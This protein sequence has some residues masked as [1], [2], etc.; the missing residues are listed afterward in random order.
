M[1]AD[2]DEH[3]LAVAK[4]D[5][6][7]KKFLKSIEPQ[8]LHGISL[9]IWA[10]AMVAPVN[11]LEQLTNSVGGPLS[12]LVEHLDADIQSALDVWKQ[13]GTREA[14]LD[15]ENNQPPTKKRKTASGATSMQASSAAS[16][17]ASDAASKAASDATSKEASVATEQ[18]SD[19]RVQ[20][21]ATQVRHN[22]TD[23]CLLRKLI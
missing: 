16:E 3:W 10:F 21:L 11:K 14:L 19:V 9:R 6:T 17:A 23:F 13:Y 1:M 4:R 7:R 8:L 5:P 20:K 22:I 15:E 12:P 2:S 18:P